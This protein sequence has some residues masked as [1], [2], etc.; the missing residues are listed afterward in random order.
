MIQF[1]PTS[2]YDVIPWR[3]RDGAPQQWTVIRWQDGPCRYVRVAPKLYE[4]KHATEHAAATLAAT[5]FKTMRRAQYLAALADE[6]R[7]AA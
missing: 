4:T 2:I 3:R 6:R 7:K 1:V 5:E